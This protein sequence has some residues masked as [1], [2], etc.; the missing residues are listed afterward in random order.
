MLTYKKSIKKAI[1]EDDVCQLIGDPD[2][3]DANTMLHDGFRLFKHL[4][5]RETAV[6]F[7]AIGQQAYFFAGRGVWF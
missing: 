6:Y 7:S 5:R 1:Y 2:D 3:T 4:R